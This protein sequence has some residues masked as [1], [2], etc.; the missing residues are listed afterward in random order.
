MNNLNRILT[1]VILLSFLFISCEKNFKEINIDPNRVQEI[2]P[3]SLLNEI[4]YNMAVNNDL[5]YIAVT[6][7]L[8]QVQVPNNEAYGGVQRY[9]ILSSTGNSIWNAGYKWANNVSEMLKVS[10]KD[11]AVNYIAVALTLRAWIYSNLSDCFGDIPFSEASKGEEGIFQAAYD[12]QESIYGQLLADLKEAN[13]LYSDSIG[14]LYGDDILFH[15]DVTLW[16]KFTNSLRL[17]LLLKESNVNPDAVQE[18]LAIINNPAKNPIID[19]FDSQAVLQVTGEGANISPWPRTLDLTSGR[20][21]ASFFVDALNDLDDPRRPIILTKASLNGQDIGYKGIPAGYDNADFGYSASNLNNEQD[22]APMF[23]PILTYAEV[24]FI[25]AELAQK[26]YLAN[27]E[28]FY[29]EGVNAAI[30]LWTGQD[31]PDTYFN[32]PHAAYNGTLERI[33][34][35]KYLS[36]YMNDYQQWDEYRRTGLPVLP[37]TQSMLNNAIMPSRLLYPSGQAIT[38][39]K[40]YK[41]E[42]NKMGGKD[43]INFKVWWDGN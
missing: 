22:I 26:G 20:K 30:K 1:P 43:D 4:V 34:M 2:S 18:M 9:E 23:I 17:R 39:A 25:K 35:Q 3:S 42:L 38:N 16:Q 8:M 33:M 11:S 32:N 37:V 29:K 15:N 13:D 27:A 6:S 19:D 28:G 7:R 5:N 40:N 24:A 14:M 12:S 36:L 21:A 31:I 41:E 10:Q